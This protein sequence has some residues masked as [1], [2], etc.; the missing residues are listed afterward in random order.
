MVHGTLQFFLG[1]KLFCFLRQKAG[2]FSIF[3]IS[4]G[5]KPLKISTHSDN[6]YYP[7][8]CYLNVCLTEQGLKKFKIKQLLKVSAFYLDKQKSFISKKYMS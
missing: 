6:S 5:V 7:Y 3:L 2:I 8:K 1:I 4:Y